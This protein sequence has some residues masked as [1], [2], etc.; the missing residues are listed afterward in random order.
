MTEHAIP[1]A[2]GFETFTDVVAGWLAAAANDEPQYT[3]AVEDATG[4]SDAVGRQTKFLEELGVL[5]A[6]GQKHELTDR[7][8]ALAAA[9]R[10]GDDDR[11]ADSLADL[12]REWPVTDHLRGILRDNSLSEDRLVAVLAAL[13]GRD[14]SEDRVRTGL[15]TLLDCYEWTGLLAC[16]DDTYRLPESAEREG[17]DVSVG[18]LL[19][20][21][22]AEGS[23]DARSPGTRGEDGALAVS[24]DL[25]LDAEPEEIER[26]VRGIRRGLT[27]DS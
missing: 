17:S 26:L 2:V 3:A 27:E 10:D 9:L 16:D 7:G 13:V 19:A 6:D 1:K 25:S 12:L 8:E 21:V 20:D 11:A 23:V 4:V 24:L 22:L 5:E 15:T 14:P 18:D